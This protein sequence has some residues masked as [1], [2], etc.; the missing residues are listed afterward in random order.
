M[1]KKIDLSNKKFG[2]LFV[3]KDTG[4]R[5]P[6]KKIIY[7]CK[8]DCGKTVEV[9][10]Y[11]LKKGDTKSCGCLRIEMMTTHGMYRSRLYK[12]WAGMLSRCDTETATGYKNY[13]GRGIT[14]CTEWREFENFQQWAFKNG[15]EENLTIERIDTNG[16]YEPSNCKW[17]TKKEQNRNKRNNV[18]VKVKGEKMTLKD[19]SDRYGMDYKT[20]RLRYKAGLR[21]DEI[22]KP[23]Q[24][25][26]KLVSIQKEKVN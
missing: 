2:R 16:N 26:V 20:I 13:G 6:S 10:G 18:Y 14:V 9:T 21:G 23:L 8:C 25:G 7:L 22:I 19:V 15:Y 5:S 4:K 12:I 1:V 17:A 3:I 24:P 11:S